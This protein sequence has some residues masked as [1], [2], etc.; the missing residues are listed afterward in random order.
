[1]PLLRKAS[2]LFLLLAF[3]E[4]TVTEPLSALVPESSASAVDTEMLLVLSLDGSR[5]RNRTVWAC[6]DPMTGRKTMQRD[7]VRKH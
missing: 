6:S 7:L 4:V 1:M 2:P 3:P 5:V